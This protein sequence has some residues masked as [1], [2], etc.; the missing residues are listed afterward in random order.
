MTMVCFLSPCAV[1]CSP[2]AADGA[3]ER[4]GKGGSVSPGG[5]P[6]GAGAPAPGGRTPAPAGALLM[7]HDLGGLIISIEVNYISR[8]SESPVRAILSTSFNS[9]PPVHFGRFLH[10]IAHLY[11]ICPFQQ[12]SST[13]TPSLPSVSAL[14]V[15]MAGRDRAVCW[16]QV[17][18]ARGIPCSRLRQ[19]WIIRWLCTPCNDS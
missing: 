14:W 6:G 10:R 19:G 4:A 12:Q 17:G 13:S 5:A 7:Q 18:A 16:E 8:Y 9:L 1:L 3:A 15:S 2:C 11:H